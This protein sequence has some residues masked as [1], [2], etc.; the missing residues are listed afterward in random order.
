MNN[1]QMKTISTHHFK[2]WFWLKLVILA[3]FVLI[4]HYALASGTD[5]LQGTDESFWATLNGTGKKYIYGIEFILAVAMY[6][7]SKNVLVFVGVIAIAVFFNVLLK[8]I[9]G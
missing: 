7:K 3:G 6:I 2:K 9:G 4:N 1:T 5:L 8:F